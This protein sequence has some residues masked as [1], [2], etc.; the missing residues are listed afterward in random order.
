[1]LQFF[2]V[3]VMLAVGYVYLSEGIF[4]A[5]VMFCGVILSGLLA[6]NFFEPLAGILGN[7]LAKTPLADYEDALALVAIFSITLGLFR[8]A[9]NNV[10]PTQIEY[11]P[12]MQNIGGGLLGLA[13]GYLVSGFL[14]CVLQ[15]LPWRDNFMGFDARYEADQGFR[16]LLPSDRV[17]LAMMRRAG[18]YAFANNEIK[19]PPGQS[20]E[21]I[22]YYQRYKTFDRFGNF[23]LRYLRYRRFP[24]SIPRTQYDG[25]FN[26]E[27]DRGP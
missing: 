2:T 20:A 4:T 10:A 16:N 14:V 18:A 9:A 25:E 12:I 11:H 15:T 22:P 27:L 8:T 13:T 24:E 17:W 23:E 26:H 21:D 3:V 19:V 1:M 5:S 6:F 7:T